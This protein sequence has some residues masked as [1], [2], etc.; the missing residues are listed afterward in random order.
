MAIHAPGCG[1]ALAG[2]LVLALTACGPQ[3]P[4]EPV[5]SID[6]KV[7]KYDGSVQCGS[8]GTSVED[9]ARELTDHGID[10]LCGQKGG[11]GHAYCAACGCGTGSIN[12][13]VIHP[14]NLA[15]AEGL[16]FARV[17]DLSDYQD[18]PCTP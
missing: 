15:D 2:A 8:A 11:D 12:V 18:E 9:M 1:P 5:G 10:V 3:P 13:Y 17:S 6:S 16:G 14:Q 4:A 7:Y